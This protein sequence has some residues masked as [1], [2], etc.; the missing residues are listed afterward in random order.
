MYRANAEGMARFV[1]GERPID[2]SSRVVQIGA[3]GH[4]EINYL[5]AGVTCAVDPLAAALSE[6]GLLVHGDVKWVS[7][8]GEQL[9]FAEGAFTHAILANMIDHVSDPRKVLAEA[10]RVLEPGGV[11]CLSCHVSR[12]WLLPI[13]RAL[14]AMKLGY[15][16]GHLWFFSEASLDALCRDAGFEV[17]RGATDTRSLGWQG[18]QGNVRRT[19]KPMLVA[20]RWL[21]LRKAG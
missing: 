20:P 17:R 3:A 7:A 18:W 13:F 4:A 14:S 8:M 11:A 12:R 16:R 15:F 6:R 10:L 19:L 5:K 9:P 1:A 2:A 21:L